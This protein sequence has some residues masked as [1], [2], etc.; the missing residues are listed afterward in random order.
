M[1]NMLFILQGCADYEGTFDYI[2]RQPFDWSDS[3][4]A[5]QVRLEHFLQG[6]LTP[7]QVS[8]LLIL[9]G[10]LMSI[11]VFYTHQGNSKNG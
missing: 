11:L 7:A 9:D 4:L 1:R 8:E 3:A 6:G 5:N 2:D 10:C